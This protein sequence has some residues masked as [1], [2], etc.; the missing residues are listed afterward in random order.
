MLQNME[1]L[2]LTRIVSF[3]LVCSSFSMAQDLNS[4][5]APPWWKSLELT[6]L[7]ENIQSGADTPG[8]MVLGGDSTV[9]YTWVNDPNPKKET[10]GMMPKGTGRAKSNAFLTSEKIYGDFLLEVEV[11]IDKDGGNSGIQIRSHPHGE[12]QSLT[13]YQIEID[14]SDRKWSGGLYDE[15]RRGWLDSLED[16]VTA[17]EAFAPGEWNTY[18]IL[19]VG[20]RIKTWI[21]DVPAADHLDMM[22]L[23]GHIGFQV[24]G[25]AC[26]VLWRNARIADLGIRK[27]KTVLPRDDESTIETTGLTR[28]GDRFNVGQDGAVITTS[29]LLPDA[30]S[31]IVITGLLESGTI[32]IQL[33]DTDDPLK[34]AYLL[35]IPPPLG[36]LDSNTPGTIE[37]IREPQGITTIIN[38][39]P[40]VPGAPDL[41]GVLKM[42]VSFMPGSKGQLVSMKVLPPGAEELKAMKPEKPKPVAPVESDGDLNTAAD[43]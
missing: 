35:R 11:R 25:G 22:D 31:V 27:W 30:T 2:R 28:S 8:W 20:P 1:S 42:V 33:G 29:D 10:S 41:P 15:Q 14:P 37:I 17:Q 18:R 39:A 3:L 6:P 21:N 32:R 40:L 34:D 13:G 9:S 24:H 26:D 38:G 12:G 4:I 5:Q 43:S 36:K 23:S 7:F 16:N 19:C